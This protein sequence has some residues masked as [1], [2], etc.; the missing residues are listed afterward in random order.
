MSTVFIGDLLLL[1]KQLLA[2]RSLVKVGLNEVENI[3]Q[4][5]LLSSNA[6][7]DGPFNPRQPWHQWWYDINGGLFMSVELM[8]KYLKVCLWFYKV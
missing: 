2:L 3:I 8:E 6:I 5:Q 4:G 7:T 1:Y